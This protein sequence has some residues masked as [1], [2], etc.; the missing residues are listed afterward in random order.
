MALLSCESWWYHYQNYGLAFLWELMI[1]LSELWPW[2][3]QLSQE[4]KAIALIVISSTLTRKQG[5]SSDSDIINSHKKESWWYHYQSYGLAFLWELVISLSELCPCF[6]VRV[7]DIT[8]RAIALCLYRDSCIV[9]FLSGLIIV[10]RNLKIV[11][12][13]YEGIKHTDT[14]RF[15]QFLYSIHLLRIFH[16]DT[17]TK[18]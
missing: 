14:I 9:K 6:L 5:H 13:L 15:N 12:E 4:S 11:V 3:H 1:S 7:D 8:I 2:Y 10:V 16:F 17:N 18:W